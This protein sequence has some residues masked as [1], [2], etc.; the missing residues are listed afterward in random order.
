M[1]CDN[2]GNIC[3]HLA[4]SQDYAVE[5]LELF[6]ELGCD[7]SKKNK[8]G[9][10]PLHYAFKANASFCIKFLLDSAKCKLEFSNEIVSSFLGVNEYCINC[11]LHGIYVDILDKCQFLKLL[12]RMPSYLSQNV[13]KMVKL[14]V[15]G[16]SHAGK[17][18]LV[19]CMMEEVKG[20]FLICFEVKMIKVLMVLRNIT[21]A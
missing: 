16:D 14:A 9:W 3:P 18:T 20:T 1:Q 8:K 19:R 11:V 2:Y 13:D 10:S 12:K 4:A 6:V 15:L 17:F 21:L 7:L 5:L